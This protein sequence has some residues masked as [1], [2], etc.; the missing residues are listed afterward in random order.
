MLGHNFTLKINHLSSCFFICSATNLSLDETLYENPIYIK[1]EN[2]VPL[3]FTSLIT[4]QSSQQTYLGALLGTVGDIKTSETSFKSLNQIK[5]L[6]NL[7]NPE[8]LELEVTRTVSTQSFPLTKAEN[9]LNRLIY[10]D[11]KQNRTLAQVS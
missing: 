9:R 10:N 5:N 6:N 11:S 4:S 2:K 8:I 7:Q 1:D 3:V